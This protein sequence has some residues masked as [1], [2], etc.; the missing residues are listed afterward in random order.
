[1]MRLPSRDEPSG[2]EETKHHYLLGKIGLDENLFRGYETVY[3][4]NNRAGGKAIF[5]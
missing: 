3:Y 5:V 4:R 2:N 1:M